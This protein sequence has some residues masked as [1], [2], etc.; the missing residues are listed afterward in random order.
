MLGTFEQ[1]SEHTYPKDYPMPTA[2]R[3]EKLREPISFRIYSGINCILY[4]RYSFCLFPC[5]DIVLM[6]VT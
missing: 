5:W 2:T 3:E 1:D 4:Q 6:R